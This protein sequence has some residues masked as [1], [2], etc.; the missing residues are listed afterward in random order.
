[1]PIKTGANKG[2]LNATEIRRL[3][4]AHNKLV[5]IKIPPKTDRDGLIKLIQNEGFTINHKLQKIV[6]GT[7]EIKLPPAPTPKTAEEK[8]QA[9]K[10]KVIKESEKEE[11]YYQARK[12]KIDAVKGM[13]VKLPKKK[14]PKS[15]IPKAPPVPAKTKA[16]KV[17]KVKQPEDDITG[18]GVINMEKNKKSDCKEAIKQAQHL[19]DGH[20][21]KWTKKFIKETWANEKDAMDRMKLAL[22]YDKYDT[23]LNEIDKEC[24]AS[25][26]G[27][28]KRAH[29]VWEKQGKKYI[30]DKSFF[31]KAPKAPKKAPKKADPKPPL[32]PT[33]NLPTP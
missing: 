23:R 17:P 10:G 21:K 26:V 15:K 14:E 12:K 29:E 4:K 2:E 22:Q 1:M 28:Y 25:A 11:K 9:K 20:A 31:K 3:I 18:E 33:E 32:N 19:L 13:N 30:V 8:A 5:S 27:K 6:K 16:S 24:G 7:I